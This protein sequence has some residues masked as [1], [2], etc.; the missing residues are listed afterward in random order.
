MKR[1]HSILIAV[2][3]TLAV[4]LPA[5]AQ[6]AYRDVNGQDGTHTGVEHYVFWKEYYFAMEQNTNKAI[7]YYTPSILYNYVTTA[8]GRWNAVKPINAY[9]MNPV[10]TSDMADLRFVYSACPTAASALGC[11]SVSQYL[12]MSSQ[13]VYVWYKSTIYV[14]PSAPNGPYYYTSTVNAI[15]GHEIGHSWGLGDMYNLWSGCDPNVYTIMDGAY[16]SGNYY[17]P[18]DSESPTSWD[19]DRWSD[20]HFTRYYTYDNYNMWG[21]GT[22]ITLWKDEA[23]NDYMSQVHWYWGNSTNG[24]FTWF[25]QSAHTNYNGSHY[26]VPPASAWRHN[27]WINPGFYGVHTKYVKVCTY[28]VFDWAYVGTER[29]SPPIFYPY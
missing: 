15:V 11:N 27:V 18:C 12:A 3:F 23:W 10:S 2:V 17:V 6:I 5:S 19:I 7:S 13:S 21:D 9:N 20:Y 1:L 8:V 4:V 14:K 29:C 24:T 25:A 22:V 28:P 16:Q 26:T